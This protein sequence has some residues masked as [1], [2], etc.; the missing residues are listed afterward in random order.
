ML[1]AIGQPHFDRMNSAIG[2]AAFASQCT[3]AT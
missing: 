3:S 2:G 1:S